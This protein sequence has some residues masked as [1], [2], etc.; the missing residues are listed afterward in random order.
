MALI[1]VNHSGLREVA[2]AIETY[3]SAQDSEMRSA[4]GEI[5]AYAHYRLARPG[6]DGIRKKMGRC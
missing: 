1:E 3:C 2:A 4:D 6:R 5:K